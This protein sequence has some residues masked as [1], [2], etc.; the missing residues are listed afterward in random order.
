[1][2]ASEGFEAREY[3]RVHLIDVVRFLE[4][5][6]HDCSS[7]DYTVFRLDWVLNVLTRY[8]DTHGTGVSTRTTQLVREA[9]EVVNTTVDD[10]TDTF[11]AESIFTGQYGRPRLI[12][13]CW[14]VY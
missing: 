9:K 8:L 7:F 11:Q 5:G 2:A 6:N 1:M 13:F 4:S 14:N 12:N 3:L 10:D